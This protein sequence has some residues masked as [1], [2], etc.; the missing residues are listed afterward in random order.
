VH[1]VVDRSAGAHIYKIPHHKKIR[2]KEQH[3]KQHP[4]EMEVRINEN[5]GSQQCRLF[6]RSNSA[7]RVN[8]ALLVFAL[9]YLCFCSAI[10]VLA[11][12]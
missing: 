6:N 10:F 9:S 11:V 8:M 12:N 2:R 4:A 1:K 3:A 7:G 5:R